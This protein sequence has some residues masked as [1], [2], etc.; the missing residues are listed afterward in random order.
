MK[1]ILVFLCALFAFSAN[2]SRAADF[3]FTGDLISDDDVRFFSFSVGAPST[4]TMRTWSYAGGVNAAGETIP[5]GGFD[6]ILALFDGAG[7][8]L[9]QNDD[10]LTGVVGVDPTTGEAFDTLLTALL[11]PGDYIVSVM[12]YANF[13]IGP[14]LADGFEGSGTAGFVD[15]TGTARTSFWAFDILG[16]ES[17]DGL[18]PP[19]AV[20]EPNPLALIVLGGAGLVLVR[21]V[22]SLPTVT[23]VALQP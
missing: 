18:A 22:R 5:D 8:L 15:V 21:R 9:D 13:A 3:S 7:N 20:P 23:R 2:P 19:A 14:T 6:P 11:S 10:D 4:V 1:G 17:A 12:Q 16:V